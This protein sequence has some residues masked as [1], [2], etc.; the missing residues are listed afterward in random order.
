MA[1]SQ[2]K[3]TN[4]GLTLLSQV[5]QSLAESAGDIVFGMEDGTVSIFGLVFGVAASSTS[6]APVLLAGGT[7]AVAAAVSMMAGAFLD[8]QTSRSIARAALA[9]ERREIQDDPEGEKQEI[10]DRLGQQGFSPQDA[11]DILTIMQRT[12][13]A[14]LQFEVAFELKLGDTADQN[15]VAHA[16]W[17]FL[18]DLFAASIPVIPFALF[19]LDTARVVSLSLTAILLLLLGIGRAIIA[20]TNLA[21]TVLET[22]AVAALAAGAGALIGK[23]LGAPAG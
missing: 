4:R 10:F 16:I 18:A 8:V 6:S 14:M 2:A 21:L 3:Q 11:R 12:P 1:A 22:L 20:H 7:G 19:P 15:P 13:D 9:K 17:M 23:W 5:K